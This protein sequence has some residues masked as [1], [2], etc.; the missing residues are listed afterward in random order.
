MLKENFILWNFN[1][2]GQDEYLI[3]VE[4]NFNRGGKKL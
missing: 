3:E 2:I 4:R 1:L